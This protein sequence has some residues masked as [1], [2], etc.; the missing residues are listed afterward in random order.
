MMIHKKNHMD[1]T[2]TGWINF[3]D[4]LCLIKNSTVMFTSGYATPVMRVKVKNKPDIGKTRKSI[5]INI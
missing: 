4:D 1:G 3:P 2:P 5:Y